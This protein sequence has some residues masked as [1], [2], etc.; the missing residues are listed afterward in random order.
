MA[1][2][3]FQNSNKTQPI[4]EAGVSVG[5]SERKQGT[6][7]ALQATTLSKPLLGRWPKSGVLNLA[8]GA[9]A[10]SNA[11]FWLN[12]AITNG[13]TATKIGYGVEGGVPYVDYRFEGTATNTTAGTFFS[14]NQSQLGKVPGRKTNVRAVVRKLSGEFPSSPNVNRGMRVDVVEVTQPGGFVLGAGSSPSV[15]SNDNLVSLTYTESEDVSATGTRLGVTLA[16]ATGDIIDVSYRIKGFQWE[17][18]EVQTPLQLNYGPNNITEPGVEDEWFLYNDGN[19]SLNTQ[20]LQAGDFSVTSVD[21]YGNMDNKPIVNSSGGSINS[22]VKERQRDVIVR[23][24]PL[25]PSELEQVQAYWKAKG[26]K[27]EWS[28]LLLMSTQTDGHWSRGYNPNID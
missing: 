15:S 21:I 5:Y 24:P 3:L 9:Q 10:V 20:P 13:I 17:F 11:S 7:D 26:Y 16:I 14:R 25:T 4:T 12:T 23:S 22:L 18:G 27:T 19:D 6:V 2:R 1:Y 28:P 8:M